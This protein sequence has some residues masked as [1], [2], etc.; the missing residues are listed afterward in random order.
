VSAKVERLI[1]LTERL[2]EALV[3]DIAA[4]EKGRAR[5]MRS[6]AP[7]MQQLTQLYNREA[8]SLDAATAKAAPAALHTRLTQATKHF[9]ETLAL[10]ARILARMRNASEGLIRAIAQDVE[11]KRSAARPYARV[12]PV[13]PRSTGAMLYN[14]V[15]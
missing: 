1:V 13:A 14:S 15:V 11:K 4:L 6:I 10:H 12:A 8:G 5:E 7:D 9:R 3:A 2:T